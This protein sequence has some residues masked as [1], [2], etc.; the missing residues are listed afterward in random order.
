MHLNQRMYEQ[1]RRIP[2]NFEICQNPTFSLT[3]FSLLH[4]SQYLFF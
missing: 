3:F 1:K 4:L 2:P